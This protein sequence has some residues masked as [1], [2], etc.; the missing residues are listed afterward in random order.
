[1]SAGSSTG[2]TD[3]DPA[4]NLQARVRHIT[5][6]ILL[7][8]EEFGLFRD[9]IYRLA[10]IS[11]SDQKK[12]LVAG[13]LNRRVRHLR[14]PSFK[15]YYDYVHSPAGASELQLMVDA[16]TTNETS[17]FR[18]PEH[19]HFLGKEILAKRQGESKSVRI[20]SAACSSGEEPYSL[21]MVC[22]DR[23][24]TDRWQILATDISRTVLE[25][26]E[27]G[28][29]SIS[30]APRIPEYYL[31]KYALKGVGNMEGMFTFNDEIK[32]GIQFRSMNLAE[33]KPCESQFDCIFLRNVMIYFD[34]ETK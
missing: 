13:R 6:T 7:S 33:R 12:A 27:R 15:S 16:L 23:L 8:D 10:R 25:R 29:Y 2:I 18:E 28:L 19:F 14:L 5:R 11:L 30:A 9:L 31:K 34:R 22:H 32:K 24:G 1:M 4:S 26:A 3:Q 21:A 20:W 17:F